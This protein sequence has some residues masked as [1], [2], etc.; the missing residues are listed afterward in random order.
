LTFAIIKLSRI[1]STKQHQLSHETSHDIIHLFMVKICALFRQFV[2][3][4]WIK[5]CGYSVS[6][7]LIW[8]NEFIYS[9]EERLFIS[10]RAFLLI[11][12]F[13]PCFLRASLSSV[14]FYIFIGINFIFSYYTFHIQLFVFCTYCFI[15]QFRRACYHAI[16][17][18][19]FL[20]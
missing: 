12:T 11:M 7:G 2:W 16:V 3:T 17:Y 13:R 8:S 4:Q 14:Y 19:L 5:Q 10:S 20:K 9:L 6:F 15:C 1:S 18:V